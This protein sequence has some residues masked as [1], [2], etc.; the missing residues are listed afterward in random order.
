MNPDVVIS[1]QDSI[2]TIRLNRPQKKNAINT[3]MY[4]AMSDLI[5]SSE[6]D[7]ASEK[8]ADPNT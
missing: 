1:V 2:A 7:A 5:E 8:T 6:S 3:D 4:Q